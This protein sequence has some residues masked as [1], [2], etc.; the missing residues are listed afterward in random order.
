LDVESSAVQPQCPLIQSDY[1]GVWYT[2]KASSHCITA[3]TER[4]DFDFDTVVAV[5]EGD[6]CK[7][8]VCVAENDDWM[9]CEESCKRSS[10]TWIPSSE[11]VAYKVMVTGKSGQ[12]GDYGLDISVSQV[13]CDTLSKLSS[14]DCLSIDFFTAGETM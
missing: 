12:S 13:G 3:S 5:Y 10:I 11:G 14:S 4:S 9:H 8:L 6:D 2:L 1:K 7:S